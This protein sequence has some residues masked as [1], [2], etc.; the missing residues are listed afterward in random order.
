MNETEIVNGKVVG[1]R[2]WIRNYIVFGNNYR[3]VQKVNDQK[4]IIA[5]A[6]TKS[7]QFAKY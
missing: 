6:Q 1:L 5:F 7:A 4:I 2:Q 3:E